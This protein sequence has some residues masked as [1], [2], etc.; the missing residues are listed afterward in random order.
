MNIWSGGGL[1][2]IEMVWTFRVWGETPPSVPHEVVE[3]ILTIINNCHYSVQVRCWVAR[4]CVGW[5]PVWRLRERSQS[6]SPSLESGHSSRSRARRAGN[7]SL[8]VQE[9][10]SDG[11]I[12]GEEARGMRVSVPVCQ[13]MAISCWEASEWQ[14]LISPAI[15]CDIIRETLWQ[16]RPD[17]FT[18]Y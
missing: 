5:R 9:F 4:C 6:V 2:R 13:M 1:V 16:S 10:L 11:I 15:C 18:F 7:N 3:I 17:F 14:R 8:S 12:F